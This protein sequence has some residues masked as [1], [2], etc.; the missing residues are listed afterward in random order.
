M[1]VCTQSLHLPVYKGWV[2]CVIPMFKVFGHETR[3]IDI[4]VVLKKEF[5]KFFYKFWSVRFR[6]Y[7]KIE[8]IVFAG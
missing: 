8:D 1:T 6:I 7:R 4:H 3:T 5:F 2:N